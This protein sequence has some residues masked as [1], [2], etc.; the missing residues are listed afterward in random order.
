V[1]TP[2]YLGLFLS[3]P[4][5]FESIK[6][7]KEGMQKFIKI[8]VA[9]LLLTI[10]TV[11]FGN[12]IKPEVMRIKGEG[13]IIWG[14]GGYESISINSRS[15]LD[16]AQGTIELRFENYSLG[17]NSLARGKVT[18][19]SP[20]TAGVRIAGR[21]IKTEGWPEDIGS[22][23]WF[24]VSPTYLSCF[25]FHPTVDEAISNA[26]ERPPF[27]EVLYFTESSLTIT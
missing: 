11:S 4:K 24:E 15:N 26:T 27:S 13:L 22:G 10:I 23:F 21:V 14:S 6:R 12:A 5:F 7:G 9:V 20:T 19:V 8:L 18:F 2:A 17:G 3:I 16:D 25:M 1:D